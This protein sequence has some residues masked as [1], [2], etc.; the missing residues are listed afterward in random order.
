MK[1]TRIIWKESN[2]AKSLP[3]HIASSGER[4]ST[5]TGVWWID[6]FRFLVNHRDGLRLA[7]FDIRRG[8]QPLAV[9]SIPHLTDDIAAK[10]LGVDLWE[11]A[12]S[13]C[14]DV[15]YSIYHLSTVDEVKIEF[16]STQ[17]QKDKTFCH[18]VAYD[19]IGNLCLAYHTGIN[20]R[21]EIGNKTWVIPKPWGVRDVCYDAISQHYYAVAVS[22]NPQRSAY[23]KTATS[24]WIY[25]SESDEWKMIKMINDMHSDA[26]QVYQGRLWL[27][28]QKGDRVLG[29]TLS[30]EKEPVVIK[31]KCFD[32]PHGLSI[33]KKGILAVTNY[34]SSD[35]VMMDISEL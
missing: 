30:K 8:A 15:E 13:G 29:V 5:L 1:V 19:E 18:G 32:F 27:P 4:Y 3:L 12:V 2:R 21:I 24:I 17:T 28:D 35:V 26:C 10:M 16:I 34:G 6:E 25:H 31:G 23:A 9:A 20:P 11:I 22:A 14:W 7:L 33:S